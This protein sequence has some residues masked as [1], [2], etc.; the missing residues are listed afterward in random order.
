M[1]FSR[2]C[3]LLATASY[4]TAQVYYPDWQGGTNVCLNDG[5]EPHWMT[6]NSYTEP[7]LDGCCVK[8]FKWNYNACMN[9]TIVGSGDW[10]V[11]YEDKKCVQ[12]CASATSPSGC[13]Y[14]G[15]LATPTETLYTDA[16]S[17]CESKLA[18]IASG[19]CQ[20]NSMDMVYA[21]SELWRPDYENSRCVQDCEVSNTTCVLPG[22]IVEDSATSLYAD[23]ATCCSTG[24]SYLSSELCEANSDP[25]STGT[26]KYFQDAENGMCKMD[27]D[28]A[29]CPVGYTCERATSNSGTLYETEAKC[30]ESMPWLSSDLCVALTS[31]VPS[32]QW[33][34][35]DI[36]D[37][38][39]VQDCNAVEAAVPEPWCGTI[40]NV[41]TKTYASITECCSKQLSWIDS[42]RC[43]ATSLG[44]T[45]VGSAEWYVAD[46]STGKCVQD[47]DAVGTP[48]TC[49]QPGG[50]A[51]SSTELFADAEACC[52]S[53]LSYLNVGLCNATSN[54]A[55]YTGS[56][57]WIV[58]YENTRCVQ[59]CDTTTA[60]CVLPGGIIE[61]SS[62]KTYADAAACC[63]AKLSYL[64]TDLCESNSNPA[65]NGTAKYFADI[66][67]GL[68]KL[69]QETATCPTG[70]TCSRATVGSGKLYDTET[71]CCT[72]SLPYID[73][74]LCV[75]RTTGVPSE[76]WFLND[77]ADGGCVQ[78]CNATAAAV[79]EPWCGTITDIGTK[80]YDTASACC[81]KQLSWIDSAT[82][83]EVSTTGAAAEY[84]P[85]EK[86]YYSIDNKCVQDCDTVGTPSAACVS[87]GGVADGNGETLFDTAALCCAKKFSFMDG[88]LCEARSV[89]NYT[90][91]YYMDYTTEGDK[92][93][94][95]CDPAS[96][97]PACG[98]SPG[99][100]SVKL[101]ADATSCCSEKLGWADQA[102]CVA[103]SNGVAYNGT[104]SYY[105]DWSVTKCAK[106]CEG[107]APCGG[108]ADKWMTTYASAADCCAVLKWVD[109]NECLIA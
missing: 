48:V 79:P 44:G 52:E 46:Y 9:D 73:S 100:L 86:W 45:I 107:A 24:L 35:A 17:C 18:Y 92:C 64:D 62:T 47:C 4:T 58:D 29:T 30:C 49:L 97:D 67:N 72:A 42:A 11:N 7:T 96:A 104:E 68:C 26:G 94:K 99:D 90:N 98:G 84:V 32:E 3:I 65:S 87:P 75:A 34:V 71:A 59:D 33:F 93:T 103:E 70:Y 40:T 16:L 1:N 39:C 19:L 63:A 22:G 69:D 28:D 23:A 106:D 5:L 27:E 31:G 102:Q 108:L 66:E 95:D 13:T 109:P 2:T 36:Q 43:N 80:M 41:A 60:T 76:K 89:G 83:E 82:C 81:S 54:G 51:E 37:E 56:E 85:T 25:T 14:F 8:Y 50:L 61:D 10:Y 38:G 53:R 12:D 101:F 15:G 55:T 57:E 74:D 88:D 105:I 6:L 21:G 78:D 91:L 20:A 77:I